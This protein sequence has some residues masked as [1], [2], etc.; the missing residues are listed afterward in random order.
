MTDVGYIKGLSRFTY[1][2]YPAINPALPHKTESLDTSSTSAH[3]YLSEMYR[4][5]YEAGNVQAIFGYAKADV[6]AFRAP[7]VVT[8]LE[9]WRFENAPESRRKLHKL[10]RA[11][12]DD[13][14]KDRLADTLRLI[15]R[16]QVV[17]K[18]IMTMRQQDTPLEHC[19]A[20]VAQQSRPSDNLGVDGVREV[21]RRYQ[22]KID[23]LM[24]KPPSRTVRKIVE[25]ITSCRGGSIPDWNQWTIQDVATTWQEALQ[26]LEAMAQQL[27]DLLGM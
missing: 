21:Y 16:D 13:R 8:Q 11:Y 3:Q 27:E 20:A 12:T 24:G 23:E 18:A 6:W 9:A 19:F 7:W 15:K 22:R 25:E 10:M 5:D 1:W 4:R 2:N 14:G 26:R 17:F